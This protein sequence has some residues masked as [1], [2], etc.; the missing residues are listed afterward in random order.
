M[1]DDKKIHPKWCTYGCERLQLVSSFIFLCACPISFFIYCYKLLYIFFLFITNSSIRVFYFWANFFK[2]YSF[3]TLYDY[4]FLVG[5]VII[6]L[7][8]LIK[9]LFQE[10]FIK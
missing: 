9:T 8:I 4:S 6:F 1:W 3:A 7:L 10:D 5:Y 2:H